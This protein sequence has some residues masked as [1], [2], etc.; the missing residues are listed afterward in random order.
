MSK[1]A[2]YLEAKENLKHFKKLE[3]ELR[4]DLIDAMFPGAGVGTL[5]AAN[6]DYMVKGTFKNNTT[7]DA[8]EFEALMQSGSLSGDELECVVFKPSLVMKIYNELP[9]DQRETLDS[10]ITVKPALPSIDV[11]PLEEV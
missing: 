7:L 9:E 10:C 5:N 2:E 3:N 8:K 11:K 6:G 4:L 1:I